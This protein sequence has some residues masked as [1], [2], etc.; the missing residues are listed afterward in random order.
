MIT[1]SDRVTVPL[2]AVPTSVTERLS[3]STSESLPNT[4]TAVGPEFVLTVTMSSDATGSS[5]T[6]LTVTC[7]VAVAVPPLPSLMV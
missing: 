2:F 1:P 5:L 7:T 4:S 3:P 6:G